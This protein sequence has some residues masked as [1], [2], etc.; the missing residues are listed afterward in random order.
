MPLRVMLSVILKEERTRQKL[1]V[2]DVSVRARLDP[3]LISRYEGGNR[4][5]TREHV[6]RL[7]KALDLDEKQLLVEWLG[8]KLQKVL[9]EEKDPE[10]VERSIQRLAGKEEPQGV[11][12]PAGNAVIN[13]QETALNRW[14]ERAKTFQL[15]YP[16]EWATWRK[17]VIR[18]LCWKLNA[19]VWKKEDL[20]QVLEEGKTHSAYSLLD[21]L[22]M[23]RS[24]EALCRL[25]EEK[26]QL[27]TADLHNYRRLLLNKEQPFP[28]AGIRPSGLIDLA[29]V[30]HPVNAA[31]STN[32]SGLY[33]LVLVKNMGFPLLPLPDKLPPAEDDTIVLAEKLGHWIIHE[34]KRMEDE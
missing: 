21:H 33:L 8:E 22:N 17:Q 31:F 20:I 34:M 28:S 2:L 25:D 19:P 4:L 26:R 5:P 10:I 16:A 29:V 11:Q 12:K 32:E 30:W 3:S 27:E 6:T 13:S 1:S 24:Y 15:Q 9:R 7:A 14:K 23:H 18:E